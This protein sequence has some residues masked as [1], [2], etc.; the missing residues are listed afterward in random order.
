MSAWCSVSKA[1]WIIVKLTQPFWKC[2]LMSESIGG[3]EKE[4]QYYFCLFAI[5]H[6]CK[7]CYILFKC[8]S[9]TVTNHS[10]KLLIT[11][12]TNHSSKLLITLFTNHSNKLLIT[13]LND[14][15]LVCQVVFKLLVNIIV[16]CVFTDNDLL[17]Y[18]K[19]LLIRLLTNGKESLKIPMEEQTIQWPKEK[20]YKYNN[21]QHNTQKTKDRATRTTLKT[22]MNSKHWLLN[23]SSLMYA[24]WCIHK[25]KTTHP[26]WCMP[27][28]VYTR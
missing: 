23:S 22:E 14:N 7:R 3:G 5:A 25:I 9:T 24:P 13:L 27:I 18:L 16:V 12:F 17:W 8:V 21:I 15:H 10:N 1:G 6:Y 26:L 4:C 2:L 19:K 28:G 11:L 20:E